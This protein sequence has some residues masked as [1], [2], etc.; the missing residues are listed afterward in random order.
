MLETS[1]TLNLGQLFKIAHEL[2]WYL[3]QKLKPK[4]T[5]NVSTTTKDKQVGSLVL[6]IGIVVVTINK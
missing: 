2:K 6:E 1:Y 5:Q 4:K 3:W